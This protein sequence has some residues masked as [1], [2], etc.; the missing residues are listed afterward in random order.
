[1]YMTIDEYYD[2]LLIEQGKE[3]AD[4]FIQEL[5][6]SDRVDDLAREQSDIAY[7]S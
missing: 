3:E 4:K 6:E 7:Y 5:A 2:F 1:M